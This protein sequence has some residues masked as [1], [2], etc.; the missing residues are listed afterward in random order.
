MTSSP[1][2]T[3]PWPEWPPPATDEQRKA[4][5]AVLDSGRWGATNGPEVE[6]FAAAFATMTGAPYAVCTVNN[7][8][9]LFLALR[10]VGVGPG[11]EVIV[12]AYT[13]VASASAVV[14][15]GAVP[16]FAD[17]DPDTLLVDPEAVAALV[18]PRT[19]A[20]MTVHISGAIADAGTPGVPVVEDA[21]QA[22]GAVRG[23]RAAGTLGD[24]G[25]FSFQAS[26]A[27]T[28]GEGGVIVT[29]DRATYERLWSLHN[30]GRRLDG[31]WYEHP[32]LGW[33]LRMTGFQ[34]AVLR[35]QLARLPAQI[36]RR[37]RSAAVLAAALADVE[38]LSVR[39]A[40]PDTERH[41][42]HLALLR[43][44]AAAFGGRTKDEFIAAMA[45]EG[46]PL[47]AG[48]RALSVEPSLAGYARPCPVA[49]GEAE[50]TVWVRQHLLMADDDAMGDIARAARKVRDAC[51]R[52]S[53]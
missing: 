46:I 39:P 53:G 15:A 23:G 32:A 48:Y 41:T 2:R 17:V 51:T 29:G 50:A 9:G 6:E 34:A 21:A 18:G 10:A 37:T 45:A 19:R 49:E 26:K 24:A 40:P 25:C 47:D 42:W 12:P 30:V 11:D 43:Y 27:M 52:V 28:A 38:G 1:V 35:P 5:L 8:V 31:G 4:L 14:L 36:D 44:D 20:V 16:V 22:H 33:N 3:A 13:F 7:T